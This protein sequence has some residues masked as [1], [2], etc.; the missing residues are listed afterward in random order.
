MTEQESALLRRRAL[1]E[2]TIADLTEGLADG[3]LRAEMIEGVLWVR[4]QLA[5]VNA[6]LARFEGRSCIA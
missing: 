2:R 6:E 5:A 4:G 3:S 1:Y